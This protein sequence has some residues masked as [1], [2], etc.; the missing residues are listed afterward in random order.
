[1]E[2]WKGNEKE[3]E[4]TQPKLL[5]N[6]VPSPKQQNNLNFIC[7]ATPWANVLRIIQLRGISLYLRPVLVGWRKFANSKEFR[8][9]FGDFE[10][11]LNEVKSRKAAS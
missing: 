1:M 7:P 8:F 11:G 5:R 4:L 9:D 2:G 3:I 6:P 10:S